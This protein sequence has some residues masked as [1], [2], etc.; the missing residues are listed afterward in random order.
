VKGSC[1]DVTSDSGLKLSTNFPSSYDSTPPC[2]RGSRKKK[3]KER[4][5]HKKENAERKKET[6]SRKY[7][8]TATVC[9]SVLQWK[10]LCRS[11]L[12][13]KLFCRSV[14]QWK[15]L[16]A[17]FSLSTSNFVDATTVRCNVLQSTEIWILFKSMLWG[18][19]D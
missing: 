9:R 8:H 7:I 5:K 6:Q 13:W 15:I 17:V 12:Q 14:L 18:G 19:Y 4:N 1:S 10:I 2:V 16:C 11:V 3:L